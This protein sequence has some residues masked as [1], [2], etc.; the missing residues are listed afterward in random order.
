[1][2]IEAG[3]LIDVEDK[4]PYA[5]FRGRLMLPIHDA[6]GAGDRVRRADS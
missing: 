3:L 4:L 5:R 2:L 1:M 6:R